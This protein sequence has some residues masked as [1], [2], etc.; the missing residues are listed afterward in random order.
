MKKYI[1]PEMEV[2]KMEITDSILANSYINVGGGS[3]HF[4]AP[5]K[6]GSAIWDNPL[7]K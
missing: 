4:D 7:G 6:E 3:D 2:I 1:T 5:K